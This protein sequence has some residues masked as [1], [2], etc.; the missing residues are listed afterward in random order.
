MDVRSADYDSVH[1]L[2]LQHQFSEAEQVL[3]KIPGYPAEK[4]YLLQL[5]DFLKINI[6]GR[7]AL[8]ENFKN[9]TSFRLEQLEGQNDRFSRYVEAVVL[10][11]SSFTRGRYGD[12][13]KAGLEFN[14]AYRIIVDLKEKE[15]NYMPAVMMEGIMQILFG[16][17]PENYQ[18]ALKMLNIKGDVNAGLEILHD[19][20]NYSR[21]QNAEWFML[22][23]SLFFLTFTQ[24]NFQSN[25]E[26]LNRLLEYYKAPEIQR[27]VKSC[28]LIR[29]SAVSLLKDMGQNDSALVYM[30]MPYP[31]KPEVP[32]Y[33]LD[34]YKYALAKLQKLDY[35]S[36][37]HLKMYLA[38]YPGNVYKKAAIQKLAWI[39][40]LEK[41]KREYQKTIARVD[42]YEK[43][44]ASADE[45][46]QKEFESQTIPNKFLLKVR[47]LFD[48]GYYREALKELLSH[49]PSKAYKSEKDGLEFT[50]RLGRIY[51]KMGVKNKARK[52]YQITIEQ[53]REKKFYFAANSA[54]LLGMIFL[55]EGNTGKAKENF[56]DCLKMNPDSYKS[57]IHQKAKAF[58]QQIK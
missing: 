23:E 19:A 57:S 54:L 36:K 7:T 35:S 4:I 21:L 52:Y 56:R 2:I 17:V 49:K 46:A 28:P 47:L 24:R 22:E 27:L 50:Y 37:N 16:S 8:L 38:K 34:Y 58:L 45:V 18:W 20:Y 5:S 32:F 51:D 39:A 48:G 53:G 55:D 25:T 44:I 3:K 10:L 43:T 1:Q 15:P 14:K 42:D 9:N 12:Y 11:E 29:Y 40:L 6:S 26:D 30:E 33:F 31:D 13:V 41:G